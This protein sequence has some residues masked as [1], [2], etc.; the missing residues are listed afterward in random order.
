V[1][2]ADWDKVQKVAGD[3]MEETDLY[4]ARYRVREFPTDEQL[5]EIGNDMKR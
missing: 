1:A 3:L 2:S 5:A 4:P